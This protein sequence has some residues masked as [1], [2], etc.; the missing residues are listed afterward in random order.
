MTPIK[1]ININTL[2]LLYQKSNQV[3]NKR[4]LVQC[5]DGYR[6]Y[7]ARLG[8]RSLKKRIGKS[9]INR[10]IEG[11]RERKFAVDRLSL[12]DSVS[13]SICPS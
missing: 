4:K 8:S 10:S 5:Y 1:I 11:E 3:Y 9:K 2:Q 12:V 13:G 7:Q 6:G